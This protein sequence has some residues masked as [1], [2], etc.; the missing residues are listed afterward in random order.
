MQH[1]A[2]PKPTKKIIANNGKEEKGIK[3]KEKH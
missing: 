2:L 1:K 3:K